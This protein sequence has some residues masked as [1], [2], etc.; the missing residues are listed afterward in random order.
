MRKIA[1]INQKGGVGKTTTAVNLAVGLARRKKR[2]LVLDIDPQGNIST[3][4][5]K[6]TQK[7]MYDVLV[8]NVDPMNAKEK[9]ETNLD[10]ITCT[11][12]LAEAELILTGKNKREFILRKVMEDI[13]DEHY[14]VVLIDCPPS[15][16]LL[17]VNALLYAE[18]A[19]I[20]VSTHALS[21]MGLKKMVDV[22]DE[23]NETFEHDLMISTIVPT[24][25]DRRNRICVDS[26]KRIHN[27]FNGMTIDPIRI[28]SKLIEAP[29][30]AKNIFDFA[31]KSR[32]AE[33][34]KRLIDF[35]IKNE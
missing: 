24:M 20:P 28:N 8:N 2:V 22:I 7:D 26:L 15:I 25:F 30:S 31:P 16:S 9:I 5:G 6:R 12:D 10:I 32:G 19:I 4:F 11:K 14:D 18:E 21:I 23:I 17:N 33:D 27:E 13:Y 34:Y 3:C 29:G 35:V 1:I